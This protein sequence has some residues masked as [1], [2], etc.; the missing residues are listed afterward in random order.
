MIRAPLGSDF[1]AE[2]REVTVTAEA[3]AL[4]RLILP[5]VESAAIEAAARLRVVVLPMP[6]DAASVIVGVVIKPA[7]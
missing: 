1:P 6:V 4:L 7:P 3:V 2:V 5:S